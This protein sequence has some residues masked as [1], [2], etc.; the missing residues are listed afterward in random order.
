MTLGGGLL[1]LVGRVPVAVA[2]Q[3][4]E[5]VLPSG[6]ADTVTNCPGDGEQGRCCGDH[7]HP[8]RYCH[9]YRLHSGAGR[10][11]R[12]VDLRTLV[13]DPDLNM[14]ASRCCRLR[15]DRACV[16]G[17]GSRP[18]G[19]HGD[20]AGSQDFLGGRDIRDRRGHRVTSVGLLGV[21]LAAGRHGPPCRRP[22]RPAR[23]AATPRQPAPTPVPRSDRWC[24]PV[25]RGPTA[26]AG[27]AT[28]AGA[29]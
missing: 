18:S 9:R 29:R 17:A 27:S 14:V 24:V 12:F 21:E 15:L 20:R 23:T 26:A 16:F 28:G 8:D 5:V 10:W 2:D 1:G 4:V 6:E 19:L 13:V 3:A 25:D 7:A 11:G 22:R